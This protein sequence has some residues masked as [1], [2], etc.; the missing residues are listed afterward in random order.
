MKLEQLLLLSSCA[1]LF[2]PAA[3]A[4]PADARATPQRTREI[5]TAERVRQHYA[6]IQAA[7]AVDRLALDAEQARSLLAIAAEAQK[8]RADHEQELAAVIERQWTAFSTFLK[9]G[10]A[11]RGFSPQVEQE[12]AQANEAEKNLRLRFFEQLNVLAARAHEVLSAQQDFL[13]EQTPRPESWLREE[14]AAEPRPTGETKKFVKRLGQLSDRDIDESLPELI[15]DLRDLGLTGGRR[16]LSPEER[17]VVRSY[18]GDLRRLPRAEAAERL[19][20]L[21]SGLGSRKGECDA[22]SELHEIA[23]QKHGGT[24]ALGLLLAE[25]AFAGVLAR[26]AG[27]RPPKCSGQAVDPVVAALVQDVRRDINL[28]NLMNGMHFDQEQIAALLEVAPDGA[29]GRQDEMECAEA[30]ADLEG[31]LA[32]VAQ[33]L[34]AGREPARAALRHCVDAAQ[35]ARMKE[36]ARK[37]AGRHAR[38]KARGQELTPAQEAAALLTDSQRQVLIDYKAC[39]IPPQNLKDPVRAGQANTHEPQA[40]ALKELRKIPVRVFLQQAPEIANALLERIEQHHGRFPGDE[41]EEALRKT[42][43][44]ALRARCMDDAT[45][46]IEQEELATALA[47]LNREEAL[48]EELQDERGGDEVV[49]CDKTRDFLLDPAMRPLL[50]ARF[51]QLENF[52]PEPTTDLDATEGAPSCKDGK[53]AIDG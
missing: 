20:E 37:G 53:C 35:D 43:E 28:V 32:A 38:K 11:D 13:I 27:E 9:E 34:C 46:A 49:L 3:L 7:V 16:V 48:I 19:A 23:R 36:T 26:R 52:R 1:F 44:L 12:T 41:R 22:R 29:R 18:L 25:P 2:S 45:F 10:E 6:T 31:A 8:V 47:E 33:D 5:E 51:E 21:K 15:G 40:R 24:D 30:L 50:E 39:L 14:L 17:E 42:L 4:V